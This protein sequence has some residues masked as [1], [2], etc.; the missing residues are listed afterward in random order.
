MRTKKV[1]VLRAPMLVGMEEVSWPVEDHSLVFKGLIVLDQKVN[2]N[3]LR[4]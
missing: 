2:S 1:C 3:T 4:H